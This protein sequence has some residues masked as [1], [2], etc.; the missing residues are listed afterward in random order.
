MRSLDHPDMQ[1]ALRRLQDPSYPLTREY[2]LS[3][4]NTYFTYI[5]NA[6]DQ[7]AFTREERDLVIAHLRIIGRAHA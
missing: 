3:E 1:I 6:D 7:N 2:W 4:R 5:S